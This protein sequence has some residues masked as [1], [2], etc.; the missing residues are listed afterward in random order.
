MQHRPTNRQLQRMGQPIMSRHRIAL[1]LGALAIAWISPAAAQAPQGTAAG[2]LSC[3]LAPSIGLI[4]GSQQRMA[5]RFAPNGPYPPE[6]YSAAYSISRY[7]D[8]R[9]RCHGTASSRQS[10]PDPWKARGR[11]GP[12]ALSASASA[13]APTSWLADPTVRSPCSRSVEGTSGS[14][15]HWCPGLTLTVAQ[16]RS[17]FFAIRWRSWRRHEAKGSGQSPAAVMKFSLR[18]LA[19][20]ELPSP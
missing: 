9:G 18:L 14:T 8:R 15:C 11:V 1:V 4:F 6:V 20:S 10:R 17:T 5:C 16:C 2:V 12:R 19:R 7:R 3:K 13:S